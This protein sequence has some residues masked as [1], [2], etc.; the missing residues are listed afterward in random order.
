MRLLFGMSWLVDGHAL[1]WPKTSLHHS[2][3][4]L[5][6]KSHIETKLKNGFQ[7]T[8]Q[9]QTKMFW[10]LSTQKSCPKS[11]NSTFGTY[12]DKVT[13]LC[14]CCSSLCVEPELLCFFSLYGPWTTNSGVCS[15]DSLLNGRTRPKRHVRTKLNLK[16]TDAPHVSFGNFCFWRQ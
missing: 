1:G 9:R 6:P 4:Q 11:S 10:H 3:V 15:D 14:K 16:S 13:S 8:R 7:G 2:A 5:L 12:S